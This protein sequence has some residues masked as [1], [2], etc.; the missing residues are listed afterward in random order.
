MDGTSGQLMQL[1][2]LI[3]KKVHISSEQGKLTFLGVGFFTHKYITLSLKKNYNASFPPLAFFSF[4][5]M[6]ASFTKVILLCAYVS[7]TKS[8]WTAVN[9]SLSQKR[10][11]SS[12]GHIF[13]LIKTKEL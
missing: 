1:T 11:F 3:I 4:L 10:L 6:R 12:Q 13:T 7:L 2:P 5:L 8:H 9:S